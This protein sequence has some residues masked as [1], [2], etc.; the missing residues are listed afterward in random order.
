MVVP[1]D[2]S[3]EE[4]IGA[5]KVEELRY[6]NE[7]KID[8]PGYFMTIGHLNILETVKRALDKK[9]DKQ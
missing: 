1:G 4:L 8:D 3:L 2:L 9:Q 7:G 6:E 5:L